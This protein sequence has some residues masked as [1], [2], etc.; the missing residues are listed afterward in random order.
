[1]NC[2]NHYWRYTSANHRYCPSCRKE[3]HR[4]WCNGYTI[5]AWVA[6]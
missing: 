4:Y 1:M 2:K 5:R 3:E 6:V